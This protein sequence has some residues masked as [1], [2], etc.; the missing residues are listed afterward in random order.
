MLLLLELHGLWVSNTCRV[1]TLSSEPS[2]QVPVLGVCLFVCL[3]FCACSGK[4]GKG[5][6][7]IGKAV[8]DLEKDRL[9][10]QRSEGD[11]ISKEKEA[12]M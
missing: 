5:S 7:F 12:S 8:H 9:W 2:T 10:K 1:N 11:K 6:G 4:S 3:F